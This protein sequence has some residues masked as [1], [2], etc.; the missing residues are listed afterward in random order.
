MGLQLIIPLGA[1]PGPL[2]ALVHAVCSEPEAVVDRV[3]VVVGERG[4]VRLEQAARDDWDSLRRS[5]GGRCPGWAHVDVR[6]AGAGDETPDGTAAIGEAVWQALGEALRSEAP[7]VCAL[8]GGR[9][10][11]VAATVTSIFA[12]RARQRDVLVDVRFDDRDAERHTGFLFPGQRAARL[13]RA[14]GGT[15]VAAS[16]GVRLDHVP[17][18]RLRRIVGDDRPGNFSTAM[19]V[20]Q[21]ALDAMA[22]PELVVDLAVPQVSVDG[23]VVSGLSAADVLFIAALAVARQDVDDDGWWPSDVEEPFLNICALVRHH[24]WCSDVQSDVVRWGLGQAKPP[25]GNA[26][27]QWRSRALSRLRTFVKKSMPHWERVLV[28]TRKVRHKTACH[29]LPLDPAHIRIE[30]GA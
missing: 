26:L 1:H 12:L 30:G 18:P 9:H 27:S 21:R 29:R 16:V 24:E 5:V 22:L 3:F 25:G 13:P 8:G 17:V 23:I 10:R 14:G 19:T 2:F 7:V 6:V 4:Q 15:L 20:G 28:P 11:A